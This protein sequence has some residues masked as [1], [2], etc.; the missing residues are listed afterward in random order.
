MN[1]LV[2]KIL[3]SLNI[4]LPLRFSFL[5]KTYIKVFRRDIIDAEKKEVDFYRSFLNKCDLI[6]DIGAYD[7]HKT[8][9]FLHFADK[10]ICC[11]PDSFNFS[12]LNARF[13]NSN[14]V[15]IKQVAVSNTNGF[16]NFN[17]HQ[18]GSAFNTLSEKWKN[19]LKK[20]GYG[21]YNEQFNFPNSAVAKVPTITIDKLIAEYGIPDFIKIDIEG[22]EKNALQGLSKKIKCVSFEANL[23]AFFNETVECIELLNSIDSHAL[24]NYSVD[25]D[26]QL[27]AFIPYDEFLKLFFSVKVLSCEIICKM[28]E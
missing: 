3:V 11:E 8:V 21:L 12:I 6:F 1:G 7:G 5:Y 4:Y 28:K 17:V 18:K 13:K 14:K 2:K 24:F 20:N 16:E 19:I 22:Y 26:L 25:E 10:V 23:P 27:S 15:I 9:A